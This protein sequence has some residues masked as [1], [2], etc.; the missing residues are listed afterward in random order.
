MNGCTCFVVLCLQV[1]AQRSSEYLGWILRYFDEFYFMINV[2]LQVLTFP[3]IALL[4]T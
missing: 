2:L 4:G 3:G 1:F